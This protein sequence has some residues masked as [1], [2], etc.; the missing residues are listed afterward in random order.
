MRRALTGITQQQL[1]DR[2]GTSFQQIGKYESGRNAIR[3]SALEIVA[4]ALAVPIAYFYGQ[5]QDTPRV[6]NLIYVETFKLATRLSSIK[7]VQTREHLYRL[8]ERIAR[9]PTVDADQLHQ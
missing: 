8:I 1:A 7:D 2:V 3:V 4:E 5:E 6:D 9:V